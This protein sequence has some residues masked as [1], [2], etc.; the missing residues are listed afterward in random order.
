VISNLKI[1]TQEFRI[2]DGS[3]FYEEARPFGTD[4]GLGIQQRSLS[5]LFDLIGLPSNSDKSQ[6]NRPWTVNLVASGPSFR[7]IPIGIER[8]RP[9]RYLD[10]Q[11]GAVGF[12]VKDLRSETIDF[13][14]I[15]LTLIDAGGNRHPISLENGKFIRDVIVGQKIPGA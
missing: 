9:M 7:V 6:Q 4:D 13:V 2:L 11:G 3:L 10:A 8:L 5:G 12:F 15:V 14:S 1:K